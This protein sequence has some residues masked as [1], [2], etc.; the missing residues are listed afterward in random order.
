MLI[1]AWSNFLGANLRLSARRLADAVGVECRNLRLGSAD[2]RGWGAASTVVTTGGATPLISAYRMNAGAVSD[3]SSW[4]QWTMDVDVVRSLVG[5]DPTEEIYFTGDGAPKRTDN[6]LGLPAIPGPAATRSLGIPKPTAAMTLA[7]NVAGG[8]ASETRVYIDTFKNNLGRESAPGVPA[9]IVCNGGSTINITA[10]DPMPG[11]YPDLTTR[12]IYVSTDG[13]EYRLVVEQAIATL[14]AA[15]GG[16]R[17][18][19]LESGGDDTKPAWEMP[20]A[21]LKGL[22]G[23]WNGMLGGF[24]GKTYH[25]CEPYKP[26]AWPVEYSDTLHYDIVGS[27]RWLENWLLL[28]TAQPFIVTGSSPLGMSHRPLDF[29]QSCASKRS[30]VN[31]GHGVCWAGPGGLC[32]VGQSGARNL[33]E[34]LI[35]PE[36]WASMFDPWTMHSNRYESNYVGFYTEGGV[37]KGFMLDPLAPEGLIFLDQGARGSY[38]DPLSDRLYLQ[39]TGNVI[40]RFNAGSRVAVTWKTGIKRH[41]YPTNPGFALVVAD[42]PVSA[43]V[44]LWANL[45]QPNGTHVWTQVFQRTVVAGEP[46]SLPS[47]Y[48]A[49]EIQARI[50]TTGP[51]QGLMLGEGIE[52][53]A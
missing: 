49:Q 17:G 38:F 2:L 42:E 52:D 48:L 6:V 31:M 14:T 16:S 33:T 21:S 12:C 19:V 13:S 45:P 11:G 28:T 27:G 15:D 36:L 24:T 25:V 43:E 46:F 18:R 30:V 7:V 9:T 32:Y 4:L 29:D 34:P 20:P 41:P 8:G 10:L 1:A 51:V 22:I 26:W 47:G 53:L 23:L 35:E 5:N 50:V 3:T 40:K 37:R 39:D 44:T